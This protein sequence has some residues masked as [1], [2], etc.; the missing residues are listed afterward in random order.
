MYHDHRRIAGTAK[1]NRDV[2]VS[3]CGPDQ[4]VRNA[5]ECAAKYNTGFHREIF[6][7]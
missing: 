5:A 1:E 6:H 2:I 4:M 3:V 7:F